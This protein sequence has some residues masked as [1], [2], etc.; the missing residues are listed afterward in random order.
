MENI[1]Q[2]KLTLV[3]ALTAGQILHETLDELENTVFYKHSLKQAVKRR[4][5]ELT[6]TCDTHIDTLWERDEEIARLVQAGIEQIAKT[7]ATMPPSKIVLLGELIENGEIKYVE[8]GEIIG[9][10]VKDDTETKAIA[11]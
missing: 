9:I 11:S 4:Q 5:K 6:N 3:T 7:I 1:E 10:A 2:A 8:N